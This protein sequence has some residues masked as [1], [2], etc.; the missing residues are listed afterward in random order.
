M[1]DGVPVWAG[2]D[3][4]VFTVEAAADGLSAELFAASPNPKDSDGNPIPARVV[5]TA[6]A[7]LGSG[8]T[9]LTGSLDVVVTGG[10]AVSLTITAAPPANQ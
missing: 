6:D 8:T 2:S 5:V 1:L 4:T 3:D 7:D 10:Q 9:P